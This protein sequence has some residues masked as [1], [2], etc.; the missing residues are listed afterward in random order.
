M[1]LASCCHIEWHRYGIF[2]S[3]KKVLWTAPYQ[4]ALE[5]PWLREVSR[6]THC[7]PPDLQMMRADAAGSSLAFLAILLDLRTVSCLATREY[8]WPSETWGSG[9]DGAMRL[10]HMDL[11]SALESVGLEKLSGR[12]GASTRLCHGEA[13]EPGKS[14]GPGEA[15][16]ILSLEA[17][18]PAPTPRPLESWDVA[19]RELMVTDSSLPA[20][21][22]WGV[23]SLSNIKVTWEAGVG[24]G[25]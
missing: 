12:T 6:T 13:R 16:A 8:F 22:F 19:T 5:R 21:D 23:G 10:R 17:D 7:R 25:A 9:E 14:C 4:M 2:T 1:W 15:C 11:G 3:S 20:S 24:D 18:R